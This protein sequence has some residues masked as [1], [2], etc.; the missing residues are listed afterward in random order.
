MPTSDE[1]IR[2]YQTGLGR[3]PDLSREGSNYLSSGM[4]YDQMVADMRKSPEGLSYDPLTSFAKEQSAGLQSLIAGQTAQQEN[5]F[6]QYKATSAAQEPLSAA[7]TRL[8]TEAGIPELSKTIGG[9]KTQIANVQ[10][11]INQLNDNITERTKGTFTSEAQRQRQV[12]AEQDPLTKQ[13]SSFG[14]AMQPYTEQLS[15]A[16]QGIA[17]KLGLI[18]ADQQKQLQPLIM[19]IDTLSDRFSR[20]ITGYTTASTNEFNALIAKIQRQQ[21][22]TDQET[23]RAND[24]AD[25]ERAWERTKDQ[26]AMEY[27]YSAKLKGIS[28]GDNQ[29]SESDIQRKAQGS[30][31]SEIQNRINARQ[32]MDPGDVTQG[33]K[34]FFSDLYAK[35]SPYGYTL[36]NIKAA[37]ASLYGS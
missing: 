24:L 26:M 34:K 36:D 19:Q 25:Q 23:A 16:Q 15:A 20:E 28:S 21:Q 35:Y 6:G 5:L 31:T 32:N 18:S 22:L 7:Y 12:A 3:T 2:A 33:G 14:I 4:S 17:T 11:M 8:G 29:P 13:L 37:A 30:L 10:N 27:S 1:V 9:F